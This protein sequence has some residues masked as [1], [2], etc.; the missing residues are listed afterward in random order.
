MIVLEVL[1]GALRKCLNVTEGNTNAKRINVITS[2]AG[3]A[4]K[5]TDWILSKSTGRVQN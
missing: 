3:E 5:I 4:L 1:S 2:A